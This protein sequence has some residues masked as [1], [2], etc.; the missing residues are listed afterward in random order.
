MAS[1]PVK[2]LPVLPIQPIQQMQPMEI[3]PQIQ[4]MQQLIETAQEPSVLQS[5]EMAQISQSPVSP[6]SPQQM[7][8]GFKFSRL[9]AQ[10]NQ[11]PGETQ[12]QLQERLKQVELGLQDIS[13]KDVKLPEKPKTWLLIGIVLCGC[14]LLCLC[15]SILSS[16]IKM[17]TK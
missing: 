17:Y 13:G 3:A 5:S 6:I 11:F 8:N 14:Y 4:P 10:L 12:R 9:K 16:F 1:S 15:A 2:P 7:S